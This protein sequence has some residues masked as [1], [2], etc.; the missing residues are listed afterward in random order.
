M[1]APTHITIGALSGVLVARASEQP[2]TI[3]F[4]VVLLIG[5]LAPD[6]DGQGSITKPGSILARF[7]P[8]PL[9]GLLNGIGMTIAGVLNFIFGH[10]GFIHAP[11]LPTIMI[12]AGLLLEHTWLMWFGV[13]YASHLMADFCTKGGIPVLS[14]LQTKKYS[15]FPVTTGSWVEAVIFTVTLCATLALG[16]AYLPKNTQVALRD[17]Y[18]SL[19]Y[20]RESEL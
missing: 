15:L 20:G 11:L 1:M 17:L 16:F 18:V 13:G 3:M 12:G 9:I 6:I 8:G 14:P 7:L 10:R 2:M 5:S 19:V 4:F